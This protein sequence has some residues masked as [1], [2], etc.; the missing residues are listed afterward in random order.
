MMVLLEQPMELPMKIQVEMKQVYGNTMIYPVCE[1]AKTFAS[2][3][4]T[5]TL[6]SAA[7]AHI[8]KLGYVVE[9]VQEVKT[10]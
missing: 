3:L 7:I 4:N 10:L 5:K 2:M 8:K 9:V 1:T 6:T